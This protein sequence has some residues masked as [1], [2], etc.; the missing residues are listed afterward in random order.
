MT[1]T[2]DRPLE[3]APAPATKPFDWTRPALAAL[4]SATAV[5]YLWGLSG[6]ANS[7]YSA[8]AQAGS[9]NWVAFLFGSSDAA[10]S[11]TVD[12]P[13]AAIW[14]MALSV[15]M[16]G[17]NSWSILVP[18]ALMGVASV[19][20]LYLFVSRY[21][22]RPAGLFAGAILATT[23]V[24]TLMFRFNNPDAA[25]TLL[26]ILATACALRGMED[27]RT[28]WM[29]LTGVF[30]GLGFLAKQ[31]QVLLIVPPLALTH[32]ALGQGRFVRR[33]RD[34]AVAGAA[35]VVS[36]GWWIALVELWPKSSRP[37][38]GGSQTNSFLELTFG[39]L[40][41]D[42]N[43]FVDFD[44]RYTR[45]AEVDVLLGDPTKAREQLGWKPRVDFRGL[46]QMMVEHDLELARR[47][48]L[49]K[50][51]MPEGLAAGLSLHEFASLLD[52]LESLAAAG[53]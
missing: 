37:Y 5:L 43:D 4:L 17:L 41:M 45:P 16:F 44:P 27:G 34:L 30:V 7:F 38:V 9:Q 33:L 13:P 39:M 49:E 23:P 52:F 25:L 40:D 6:W 26:M 46:V 8:A 29:V 21:F 18:Q 2:L 10:N 28:R 48:K 20:L 15:K 50:S 32:L 42:Y 11:I 22:G 47:E 24:A 36:A 31:L 3:T 35:M 14:V 1:A 53:K 12:K 19:F 51:I